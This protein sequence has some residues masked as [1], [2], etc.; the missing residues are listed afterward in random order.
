MGNR[1]FLSEFI[2]EEIYLVD[3][4][5]KAAAGKKEKIEQYLIITPGTIS[6][7]DTLFLHKIFDAINVAPEQL[8]LSSDDP[9]SR[10]YL[11]TFYFGTTPTNKSI[12][13]YEKHTI[14]QK[15]VI[16]ADSLSEIA[17]DHTKKRKLWSVLQAHF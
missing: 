15:P 7:E 12:S 9:E 16:L 8:K 1:N 14:N 13:P 6:E 2:K 10:K 3:Q 4:K 11:A 5:P 17:A